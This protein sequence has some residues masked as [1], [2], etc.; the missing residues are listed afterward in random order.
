MKKYKGYKEFFAQLD[1][2]ESDM[3]EFSNEQHKIIKDS[4]KDTFFCHFAES[5]ND[6]SLVKHKAWKKNPH[7]HIWENRPCVVN[8]ETRFHYPSVYLWYTV[9]NYMGKAGY[10]KTYEKSEKIKVI[11]TEKGYQFCIIRLKLNHPTST[12]W[13]YKFAPHTLA[14]IQDDKIIFNTSERWEMENFCE[15]IVPKVKQ[16]ETP[17]EIFRHFNP[18]KLLI[19][20]FTD[21]KY[22]ELSNKL[23]GSHCHNTPHHIVK[24]LDDKCGYKMNSNNLWI[25]HIIGLGNDSYNGHCTTWW[26]MSSKTK[27][28]QDDALYHLMRE[29]EL[30]NREDFGEVLTAMKEDLT[31]DMNKVNFL[32]EQRVMDLYKRKLIPRIEE[33]METRFKDLL[34]FWNENINY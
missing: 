24:W 21:K 27:P 25:V 31:M 23:Y 5:D 11:H 14:I 2:I 6:N 22:T 7:L 12:Y 33:L 19:V 15:G 4:G 18:F 32:A 13:G 17:T 34:E 1:K 29:I 26:V 3:E 28:S 8:G 10:D 16:P 30:Y 20:P 9:P